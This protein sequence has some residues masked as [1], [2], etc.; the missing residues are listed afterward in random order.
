MLNVQNR[1]KVDR[2]N[3]F[4]N[5]V[6]TMMNQFIQ[7]WTTLVFKDKLNL[8]KPLRE[9]GPNQDVKFIHMIMVFDSYNP[10]EFG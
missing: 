6:V 1:R 8:I 3:F 9:D 7:I 10:R 2:R 4:G 5:L